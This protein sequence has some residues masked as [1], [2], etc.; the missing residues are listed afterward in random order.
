MVCNLQR[1]WK[2]APKGALLEWDAIWSVSQTVCA[3]AS[4]CKVPEGS[5][6]HAAL[7]RRAV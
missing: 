1:V 4:Q 6:G 5:E 3:E 2:S 7:L